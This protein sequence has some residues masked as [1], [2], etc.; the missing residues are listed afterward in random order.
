MPK[1]RALSKSMPMMEKVMRMSKRHKRRMEARFE[2][3]MG[4]IAQRGRDG[5]SALRIGE[6]V[7]ARWNRAMS[8]DDRDAVGLAMATRLV[9]DG[10]AVAT[11]GNRFM[12]RMHAGKAVPPAVRVEDMPAPGFTRTPGKAGP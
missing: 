1:L 5:A 11:S 3:A 7:T 9:R 10:L 6:A 12:L 2:A 4:V 8:K